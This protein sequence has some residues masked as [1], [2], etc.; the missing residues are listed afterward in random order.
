MNGGRSRAAGLSPVQV[1][2]FVKI[3]EKIRRLFVYQKHRPNRY[4]QRYSYLGLV[5]CYAL[6]ACS[7]ALI[8]MALR[9]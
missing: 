5:I 8:I 9:G 7:T 3:A 2:L 1:S 6:G 4:R